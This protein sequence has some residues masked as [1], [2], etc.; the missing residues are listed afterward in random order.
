MVSGWGIHHPLPM[1]LVKIQCI[2]MYDFGQNF[3]NINNFGLGVWHGIVIIYIHILC[4]IY[5]YICIYID[6]Y[7]YIYIDIYIY[8]YI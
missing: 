6:I 7:I 1:N 5:I 4:I 8:I 3:I 2:Y